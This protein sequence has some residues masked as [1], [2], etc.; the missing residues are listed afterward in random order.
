MEI[1]GVKNLFEM[2]NATNITNRMDMNE[3]VERLEWLLFQ[4]EI[5]KK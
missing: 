1:V 5:G 3:L 2:K 4:E